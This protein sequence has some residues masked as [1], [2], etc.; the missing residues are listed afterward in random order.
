MNNS[1]SA[2]TKEF[3]D[4]VKRNKSFYKSSE[5]RFLIVKENEKWTVISGTIRLSFE[6]KK[7]FL[8]DL[9]SINDRLLVACKVEKFELSKVSNSI[10][11]LSC[12]SM[13]LL[14]RKI[15]VADQNQPILKNKENAGW[16]MYD[17]K[18][19]EGWPANIMLFSGKNM[20]DIL[21]DDRELTDQLRIQ[22]PTAFSSLSELSS[23]LVGFPILP[24][25]ATRVYLV[26]PLY[27]KLDKIKLTSNGTLTATFLF[28]ESLLAMHFRISILYY[29]DSIQID[30][31]H[32]SIPSAIIQDSDKFRRFDI[33]EK[34]SIKGVTSADIFLVYRS[35]IIQR[36]HVET[37]PP[38]VPEGQ[39]I[40]GPLNPNQGVLPNVRGNLLVDVLGQDESKTLEFKS[41]MIYD[42]GK[43]QRSKND[44]LALA[45]IKAIVSFLNTDD[46]EVYVGIDPDRKV[47]G[48]ENDFQYIGKNKNFDGWTGYLTNLISK[49]LNDS[50]FTSITIERIQDN[51]KTVARIAM[52]RHFRPTFINYIDDNGEHKQVFYIRGLNGKRLLSPE[53][54]YQYIFS[55]WRV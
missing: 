47:L 14:R 10:R 4:T 9:F 26:A 19:P 50:A 31:F 29:S 28:H 5:Y 11:N 3:I 22:Q 1:I 46:G 38:T 12:G 44:F 37:T 15:F 24:A 35:K 39:F 36:Y 7:P 55:H 2:S 17:L 20:G 43:N 21:R 25:S 51:N 33:N 32:I 16:S 48:I 18:D 34:R 53:E 6:N 27:E 45:L 40:R 8:G 23:Q 42:K 52:V 49:H 54:T 30:N 41:S 13:S